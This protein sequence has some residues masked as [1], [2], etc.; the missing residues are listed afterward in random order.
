MHR[1]PRS[2]ATSALRVAKLALER[3]SLFLQDVSLGMSALLV[4]NPAIGGSSL[5]AQTGAQGEWEESVHPIL[6]RIGEYGPYA[7]LALVVLV[8]LRAIVRRKRYRAVHVLTEDDRRRVRDAIA[9]VEKRS[10]GEVVPVVLERS[11]RHPEAKWL[12]ALSTLLV[13]SALLEAHLPWTEP[14]WLL[15]C[16]IGL[17]AI[18]YLFAETLPDAKRTFVGEHRATEMAEEQALQEFHRQGLHKTRNA[19]GVLIFVSLFERRVIVLGDSGIH[20]KVGD[21]HWKSVQIAILRGITRGSLRD[22]L[23]AGIRACG[24]ELAKH[25]PRT[26]PGPNEIEDQVIVR[27]E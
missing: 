17:G 21:E 19:T 13:G 1:S 27:R 20:A 3:S 5:A 14:H 23:L 15:L 10:L 16:Q 24:D 26:E 9:D 12:C 4:Q 8:I 22:G 18:G 7:I 25:F 6:Y 2:L 11:D